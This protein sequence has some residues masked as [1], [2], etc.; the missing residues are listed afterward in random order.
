M[1]DLSAMGK[2]SYKQNCALARASDVVGERWTLLLVRDLLVSPRRFNELLNSLKGIGT[3]LLA[4]RL[5]DL[6]AADIIERRDGGGTVRVYALTERGQALEPAVLALIRWG[7]TRGPESRVGDQ[8]RDD[9]DLL[10]LKALFQPS[11]AADL[12][13]CVQFDAPEFEGWAR[14]EDQHM[15]IGVGKI[16]D[17]E[18]GINGTIKDLFLGSSSAAE[19]LTKGSV[20]TLRGFMSAFALRA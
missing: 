1:L 13:I 15:S 2:R 5:K 10:A 18:I 19:L 11:R 20:S 3:N 17:A 6:E 14:I 7:L 4:A 12:S 16:H 9:W 8:H